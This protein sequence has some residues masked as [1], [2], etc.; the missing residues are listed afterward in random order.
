[1]FARLACLTAL[2]ASL[3]A[4]SADEPPEPKKA[5]QFAQ[6][7]AVAPQ[8]DS[9]LGRI[10][11]PAAAVAEIKRPDLGDVRVFDS[12]GRTLSLALGY[13][14]SGESSLLK[15]QDLPAIPIQMAPSGEVTPINV[16]VKAG[17]ATK[18]EVFATDAAGATTRRD[19]I[20]V[21][22]RALALPVAAMELAATLPQ[23]RPTT[24][25]IDTG[26]DL[27]TWE[28]LAEK[29]LLRPGSD[30]E[31]LGTPRIALPSVNLRDRYMRISWD[32]DG[33]VKLT[34]AK[35][36]EATVR[37][38][39][40][41]ELD[42]TGAKLSNP[43]ELRFAPQLA[44][45]IAAV[46]LELQGSDG[47]V[48]VQLFGRDVPSQPWGLLA[49]G[50]L[51]QGGGR[52]SLELSGANLREYRIVAD[53]R[54]AGFSKEPKVTLAVDPVTVFAAFNDQP[55]FNLAVGNT[56]AKPAWFDPGDLGTDSDL[57]RAWKHPAEIAGAGDVPVILLA[58]AAPESAFE[59]RKVALWGAL[60]LATALL[61][62]A[63][64]RLMRAGAAQKDDPEPT[65][66]IEAA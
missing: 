7:L 61:A 40:R 58:P 25:R 6:V 8:D 22:T 55:P 15:A 32:A 10:V 60:L 23:G 18:V 48:P 42:T 54:S 66:D 51:K 4:C 43:H 38:P 1:M 52:I 44:V 34:G 49:T 20:L 57:L 37:Q 16:A 19:A 31:V 62:F 36:F 41:I 14:K 46:E 13:D 17:E 47:I 56:A 21:D 45:P 12:A 28:P 39:A 9:Q 59:P 3:A 50:T 11:L 29:V 27:K 63:A 65:P 5:D 30:P 53:Q 24:F 64:F 2:T 35:L 33:D 26:A